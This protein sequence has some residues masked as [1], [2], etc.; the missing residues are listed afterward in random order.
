MLKFCQ[1]S[2]WKGN[3]EMDSGKAVKREVCRVAVG[4]LILTAAMLGVFALIGRTETSVL[5]GGLYGCVVAVGNFF[6]LG[7]T[8]RRIAD[9]ENADDP[10]QIAHAKLKMRSSYITRTV[11]TGALL[12]VGLAVLKLNWIACLVPL[13]FPRITILAAQLFEKRR[14][15][16][17][18][19]K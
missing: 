7:V 3:R 11:V 19:I 2:G 5:L 17:S 10:E 6:F 14:V 8:V 4:S 15:K 1:D 16:G 13:I 12:I 18:E 9:T